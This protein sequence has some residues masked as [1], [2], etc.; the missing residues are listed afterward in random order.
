MKTKIKSIIILFLLISYAPDINATI[1][2]EGYHFFDIFY[3]RDIYK[4][5]VKQ[6]KENKCSIEDGPN[7]LFVEGKNKEEISK[8]LETIYPYKDDFYKANPEDI[9]VKIKEKT[10]LLNSKEKEDDEIFNFDSPQLISLYLTFET[11][12]EITKNKDIYAPEIMDSL[13]DLGRFTITILGKLRLSQKNSK[14]YENPTPRAPKDEGP[15]GTYAFVE[16]KEVIFKFSS[17]STISSVHIK[18]NNYNKDNKAFYLYGFKDG[19]KHIISKIQ[20]VPNNKWLRITGDGKKYDSI[21]LLRGF[22][23]DNFIIN[24]PMDMGNNFSLNQQIKNLFGLNNKINKVIKDAFDQLNDGLKS[25]DNSV[26]KIVKVDLNQNDII[27]EQEENFDIPEELMKEI[28]K[29]EKTNNNNNKKEKQKEN[30]INNQD[31]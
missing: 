7:C 3:Y 24:A 25:D 18:R 30:N 4:N 9:L 27:K 16:S 22:D 8:E 2:K 6:K 26:I 1:I 21:G 5:L 17:K 11:Y 19:H 15:K 29:E 31:L 20:N 23:Y 12:D 14:F 28:N 10:K 13:Y